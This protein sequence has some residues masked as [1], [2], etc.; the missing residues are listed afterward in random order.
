M[1]LDLT[2]LTLGFLF[3]LGL[4]ADEVGRR[5]PLPRVTLLLA[6][7]VLVGRSGF[8]LFPLEMEIWYE[9]FS[10]LALTMVA[11]LLGGI[12]T[13]ATL[14]R[15]G[16][17]IMLISIFIVLFTLSVVA[18]GLWL[19]GVTP[20]LALLLGAIAT[21]TAP[22]AVQDVLRQDGQ[23]GSFALKI[24]GI[25][26]IDD[27]WGIIAFSIAL[28]VAAILTG[29]AEE[30]LWLHAVRDLGGGIALGAAIG[31]P[32]AVLTGRLREGE[33]TQ[34]EALGIVFLT[35]GAALWL[36]VSF[37]VAGITAGAIVVNLARH[38]DRPF[39]EIEHIQ[40]PFMMLFFILAGASLE[41]ERLV[42]LGMIGL[43]YVLLRVASRIVGGWVGAWLGR[44]PVA[45]RP[46]FGV[47]LMPQAGVAIGMALVAANHFPEMAETI[48]AL[49]IGTTVIFELFGPPATLLALRRAQR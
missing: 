44:A 14:R 9:F 31:V 35:A 8:D 22:A 49:T 11:F 5:T 27:A 19:L 47:A 4:L 30:G 45:Q 42:D 15:H 1:S 2:F 17:E 7:G 34:T 46:W 48:L 24:K 6:C 10:I 12:F 21:A 18:G 28:A 41:L 13:P 33:P 20:A 40:W 3:V 38:H 37:L 39:H 32:A 25:V 26:A 23:G 43:G 16:R 36:E 29:R